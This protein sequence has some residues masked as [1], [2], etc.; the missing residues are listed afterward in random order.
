MILPYI[1]SPSTFQYTHENNTPSDTIQH[2]L[3]HIILYFLQNL[4]GSGNVAL[5]EIK[6]VATQVGVDKAG[7]ELK[8]GILFSFDRIYRVI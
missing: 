1:N 5:D 6:N 2:H 7:Q 3:L 8:K 4:K